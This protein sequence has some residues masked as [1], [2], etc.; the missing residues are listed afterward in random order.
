MTEDSN[1]HTMR[2]D[3]L[4]FPST[5]MEQRTLDARGVLLVRNSVCVSVCEL[6][7]K[8]NKLKMSGFW[9]FPTVL[10][11][12]AAILHLAGCAAQTQTPRLF[13]LTHSFGFAETPETY[14]SLEKSCI[15]MSASFAWV[16]CHICGNS[17]FGP[18]SVTQVARHIHSAHFFR[19]SGW[20]S[21]SS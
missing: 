16:R 8:S 10:P 7:L 4:E 1:R 21:Q 20:P 9:L 13:I 17:N 19:W 3:V 2:L 5:L 14:F 18:R 12:W 11:G 6:K 15:S